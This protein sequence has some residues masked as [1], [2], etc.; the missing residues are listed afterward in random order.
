MGLTSAGLTSA[1]PTS[2][3]P[4]SAGPLSTEPT[5]KE[6][7]SA[8]PISS[9]LISV[10]HYSRTFKLNMNGD[11]EKGVEGGIWPKMLNDAGGNADRDTL[12]CSR[13]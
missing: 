4:N 5:S 6:P 11:R 10:E 3:E 12:M 7:T 2:A 13:C 1:E 8:K 9:E